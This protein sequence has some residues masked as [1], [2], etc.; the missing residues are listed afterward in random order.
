MSG[1]SEEEQKKLYPHSH[2]LRK[3]DHPLSIGSVKSFVK[4]LGNK[5]FRSDLINRNSP[6]ANY[7]KEN[8]KTNTIG[9]EISPY[10]V[11]GVGMLNEAWQDTARDARRGLLGPGPFAAIHTMDALGPYIPDIPIDKGI[12]HVAHKGLGIDKPIAD[13]LGVGGEMYLTRKGLQIANKNI[14]KV[15]NKLNQ[16]TTAHRIAHEAGQ[17][18]GRNVDRLRSQ[19]KFAKDE[20]QYATGQKLRSINVTPNAYTNI[21]QV[22]EGPGKIVRRAQKIYKYH[23]GAIPFSEAM[24]RAREL[25]ARSGSEY[26][27]QDSELGLKKGSIT[28]PNRNDTNKLTFSTGVEP[29]INWNQYGYTPGTEPTQVTLAKPEDRQP[30]SES[31][32]AFYAHTDRVVTSKVGARGSSADKRR[33]LREFPQFWTNPVTEKVYR[34]AWKSTAFVKRYTLQPVARQFL[35]KQQSTALEKQWNKWFQKDIQDKNKLLTDTYNAKFKSVN[36]EL[37]EVQSKIKPY[38]EGKAEK[39]TVYNNL[40]KRQDELYTEMD[41]LERGQVY[42][43][44]SIQLQ[45]PKARNNI[46]DNSGVTLNESKEFSLGDVSNQTARF[47]NRNDPNSLIFRK[48]KTR[49]EMVFNKA[50]DGYYLYP[51][52]L[53]NSSPK[54]SGGR[55]DIIRIESSPV[56]W[57]EIPGSDPPEFRPILSGFKVKG[58]IVQGKNEFQIDLKKDIEGPGG[59]KEYFSGG[60]NDETVM[61]WLSDKF[62]ITPVS[63]EQSFL[64]E[65][66]N[67]RLSKSPKESW[68]EMRKRFKRAIE[69]VQA[70]RKTWAEVFEEVG[71]K[72]VPQTRVKR[73]PG[74]PKGSPNKNPPGTLRRKRDAEK[75]SKDTDLNPKNPDID[76]TKPIDPD[77]ILRD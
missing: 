8:S 34:V 43:E 71:I 15:Y 57:Q 30:I 64:K 26:W 1:L 65:G 62:G 41:T 74:R 2:T 17:N 6:A 23:A 20:F 28:D 14:P 12:S 35:E 54:L 50:E 11:S 72:L 76:E 36:D 16:S 51:N 29:A 10:V 21:T 70:K 68:T 7:I 3:A 63:Q 5:Q 55:D 60:F 73:G 33:A 27:Y 42:T 48:L 75:F 45:S 58:G 69:E 56:E 25:P 61:Q 22:L 18:V 66:F 38:V 53:A 77:D 24:R 49:L 31:L 13:V 4:A 9:K 37:I 46:L 59:L 19:A 40:L 52:Y 32:N 44:H 67:I 39:G 47:E